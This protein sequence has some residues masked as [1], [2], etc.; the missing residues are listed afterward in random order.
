LGWC[1]KGLFSVRAVNP[2]LP[3]LQNLRLLHL[4]VVRNDRLYPEFRPSFA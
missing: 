2:L 4:I 1:L 3:L